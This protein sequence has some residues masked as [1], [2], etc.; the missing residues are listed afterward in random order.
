MRITK[1]AL[2]AVLSFVLSACV[3]S[4]VLGNAQSK[5]MW[6]M[7][8][9]L[10]GFD[11]N[12]VNLFEQPMIKNRMVKLLGPHYDTTMKLLRTANEIQQEGA[13]FYV[14]SRYTPLPGIAKQTAEKAGFVWNADTNQ[15]AV[16]LVTGGAPTV[17]AE[18]VE[19][20]K[21]AIMPT[22]PTE[23][24]AVIDGA[25]ATQKA[26]Q[27]AVVDKTTEMVGE[28]LGLEGDQPL[29]EQVIES[30]LTGESVGDAVEE[31]IQQSSDKVIEDTTAPARET[32]EQQLPESV[33]EPLQDIDDTRDA[34]SEKMEQETGQFE[35]MEDLIKEWEKLPPEDSQPTP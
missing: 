29:L 34:I 14:V 11:P 8:K 20:A 6:A 17:I 21:M 32:L 26:L 23:L 13:L 28:T 1:I 18:Q 31:H 2:V 33:T 35:Q 25:E 5:L 16:M 24:Q 27:D 7:L 30:G 9:P 4:L 3:T 10:V 12:E 22:W 19:N 15:M